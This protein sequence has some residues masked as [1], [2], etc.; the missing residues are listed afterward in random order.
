MYCPLKHSS[1]K[2][3]QS[4]VIITM[5]NDGLHK[6]CICIN[7]FRTAH[8]IYT[9]LYYSL[10]LKLNYNTQTHIKAIINILNKYKEK[11]L[12]S[13]PRAVMLSWLK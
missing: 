11:L 2:Y 3:K 8:N 9:I 12:K 7:L 13:N 4:F 6:K 5:R 10:L 1:I